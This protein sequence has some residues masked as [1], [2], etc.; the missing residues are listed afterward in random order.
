MNIIPV[1][2][3]GGRSCEIYDPYQCYR[4]RNCEK[5]WNKQIN[6]TQGHYRQGRKQGS[7]VFP[8]PFSLMALAN[9]L[10]VDRSAMMRELKKMKE[11]LEVNKAERH[12]RGGLATREKYLQ[13][14]K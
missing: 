6:R 7:P 8:L 14:S 12:I 3:F 10:C 2:M 11:V 13:K 1:E 9:F 5:V 4:E